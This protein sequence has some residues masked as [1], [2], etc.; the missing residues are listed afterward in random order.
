MSVL[1]PLLDVLFPP[2]CAACRELLSAREEAVPLLSFC[3]GC[4]ESLE[5]IDRCCETC[6]LPGEASPCDACLMSPPPFDRA[7]AAFHYGGAISDVLHRYKY[8]DHPE[9]ARPLAAHL[10]RLDLEPPDLVLPVPLHAARRRS[11]TYDQALYLAQALA[12]ARGWRLEPGLVT[13][14]RATER[15]VG[16]HRDERVANVA[17]AFVV[18]GDVKGLSVLLVDDVVT[19]GATAAECARV[20]KAAG[21][22]LVQVA[23]VARAG[24]S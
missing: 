18:H 10:A 7:R 6:G 1:A 19:T 8:E 2:R 21:A 13:R 15:Q 9:F 17:G 3:V 23:A 11:R 16:R 14:V 20:L 22:R 24:A 4:G 5:P 12:R